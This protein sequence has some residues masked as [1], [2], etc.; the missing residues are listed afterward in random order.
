MDAIFKLSE[1]FNN[2]SYDDLP[3][4]VVDATKKLILDTISVGI[5]GSGSEG[6]KQL[7][8]MFVE[9]GGR[10]DS[11]AWVFGNRLPGV[12]AAQLNATMAH[13]LDFDDTHDRAVIHV[14]VTTVPTALAIA[15]KAGNIDGKKLITAVALGVEIASRL[16]LANEV[17]MF[18][19]GWHYTTLHGNFSAAAVAG[20]LMGLEVNEMISAYGL[21]YHQASGNLQGLI[22]GTL[23]KRLGPG[24]SVRNG[25]TAVQMAAAGLTGPRNSLMG[26]HG[27]FNVYHHG[28]YNPEI[29]LDK[30]GETYEVL[31]LSYKPYPCCRE[32]HLSIDATLQLRSEFNIKPDD[33]KE[34]IVHMSREGM[35]AVFNPLIDKQNPKNVV[36]AQ[37][38]T[39]WTVSW[40]LVYGSVGIEAFKP[41]AIYNEKVLEISRRVHPVPDDS[42][43]Q[44][45]VSPTVV[46]IITKTGKTYT[47]KV[48]TAYGSPVNPMGIQDMVN[49]MNGCIA[50]AAR[51]FSSRAADE[52]T[53]MC[54]NLEDVEDV[55]RI[56]KI[57]AAPQA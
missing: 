14:G 25:I 55:R 49:K 22:D 16:C 38:S 17:S 28:D 41:D 13:A 45:G 36:D 54:T 24:F 15:D 44:L 40:A 7:A 46:N 50:N 31:N 57:L 10:E 27:L 35:V 34:I 6:V 48:E 5:G 52:L 9:Q 19:R 43:S 26:K 37:F 1:T 12:A 4:N 18:E 30:L 29:L 53:A 32:N 51:H 21:A 39:P 20:K 56:T 3:R 8:A 47:K 23:A 2:I 11:F 33:V 42:L